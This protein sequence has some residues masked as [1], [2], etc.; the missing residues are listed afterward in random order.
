MNTLSAHNLRNPWTIIILLALAGILWRGIAFLIML[1]FAFAAAFSNG[2]ADNTLITIEVLAYLPSVILIILSAI[3]F[4]QC[5]WS[6]KTLQ[7]VKYV[8]IGLVIGLYFLGSRLLY[9]DLIITAQDLYGSYIQEKEAKALLQTQ[10]IKLLIDLSPVCIRISNEQPTC[11]DGKPANLYID[12]FAEQKQNGYNTGL[13][14]EAIRFID[15]QL[16]QQVPDGDTKPTYSSPILHTSISKPTLDD[17]ANSSV[18][19]RVYALK[20]NLES[21]QGEVS[22]D[23]KQQCLTSIAQSEPLWYNATSSQKP[24]QIKLAAKTIGN[25]YNFNPY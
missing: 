11:K 25:P 20:C 16:Q 22:Y 14:E 24:F 18:T 2:S 6:W 3:T 12:I 19:V 1:P 10:Q 17:K 15:G 4:A 9:A 7:V 13:S 5:I 23:S 21:F 8:L